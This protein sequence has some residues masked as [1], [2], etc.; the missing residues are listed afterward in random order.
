MAKVKL[1][2]K[3]YL[4][5]LDTGCVQMLVQADLVPPGVVKPTRP[6]N[7]AYVHGESHVYPQKKLRLTVLGETYNMLVGLADVLPCSLL[8]GRDWPEL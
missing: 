7:V 8:V 3:E 4:A 6:K 1:E 2:D 5:M